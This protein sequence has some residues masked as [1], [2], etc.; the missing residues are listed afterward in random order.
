MSETQSLANTVNRIDQI[1]D[2][3]EV[4]VIVTADHSHVMTIAGYTKRGLPV[5]GLADGGGRFISK[6]Y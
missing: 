1:T 5:T 4:M 2:E 3:N 6:N